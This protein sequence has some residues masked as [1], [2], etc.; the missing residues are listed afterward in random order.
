MAQCSGTFTL[1]YGHLEPQDMFAAMEQIQ[2][3]HDYS[4]VCSANVKSTAEGVKHA[5]RGA[6][7]CWSSSQVAI[8]AAIKR[9]H[10]PFIAR[11]IKAYLCTMSRLP[12]TPD[13]DS[14][15]YF[16][17]RILANW[18]GAQNLPT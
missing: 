1:A 6:S 8:S 14:Q 7:K 4:K 17:T 15:T 5:T 12:K 10:E 16:P 2:S 3:V 11:E 13:A 18:G 9:A